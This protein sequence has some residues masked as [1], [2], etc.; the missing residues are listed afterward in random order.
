MHLSMSFTN[1]LTTVLWRSFMPV[2]K[3]IA[4]VTGNHLYSLEIYPPGFFE[5]F[6]PG[7][8]FEKWAAVELA[9]VGALPATVEL[10]QLQAGHY[11]V[12]AHRGPASTG[13]VT[14]QYIFT[15]WLPASG[16]QLDQRPHFALMTEKYKQEAA[17]SEEEIWIPVKAK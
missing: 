1:N 2:R 5:P 16:Y 11:A 4:Q 7:R 3:K 17:D 9:A 6:D 10:L 14:Y 13:A 12:F 15:E 8:E